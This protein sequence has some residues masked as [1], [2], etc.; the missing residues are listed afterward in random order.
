MR[1]ERDQPL[2]RGCSILI[3]EYDFG[4]LDR[5]KFFQVLVLQQIRESREIHMIYFTKCIR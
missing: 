2:Y 4:A 5:G 3:G 1:D